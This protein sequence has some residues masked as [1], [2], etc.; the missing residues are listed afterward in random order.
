MDGCQEARNA[1]TIVE[2]PCPH[3]SGSME[4]FIKDGYLAV[5]A[6]CDTCG[7]VIPAG[8]SPE[9][10]LHGAPPDRR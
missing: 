5:D 7:A 8:S 2:I 1:I 9:A 6:R 4:F 3:C 10:W